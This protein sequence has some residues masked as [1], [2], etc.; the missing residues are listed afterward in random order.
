M[1][2]LHWAVWPLALVGA[3][4]AAFWIISCCWGDDALARWFGA[5]PPPA[6]DDAGNLPGAADRPTAELLNALA[7]SEPRR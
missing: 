3:V 1:P 5:A 2:H 6:T 4:A 7:T